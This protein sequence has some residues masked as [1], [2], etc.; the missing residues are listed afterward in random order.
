MSH[1]YASQCSL[2]ATTSGIW[3]GL[4]SKGPGIPAR[5][6]KATQDV[7]WGRAEWVG[8]ARTGRRWSRKEGSSGPGW[9]HIQWPLPNPSPLPRPKPSSWISRDLYQLKSCHRF[10]L[11]H[12]SNSKWCIG[13][14]VVWLIWEEGRPQ[15]ESVFKKKK[16]YQ[17]T[18]FC[19]EGKTQVGSPR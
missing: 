3:P 2:V 17:G 5:G 4:C 14:F 15:I 9:G 10:K 6:S 19:R 12:S 11:I 18:D 16:N 7:R 13:A 1:D 8:V